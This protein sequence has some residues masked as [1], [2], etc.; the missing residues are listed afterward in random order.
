[1]LGGSTTPARPLVKTWSERAAVWNSAPLLDIVASA[2]AAVVAFTYLYF[3]LGMPAL[4]MYAP[5]KFSH[6]SL[7]FLA[8]MK[9]TVETGWWWYNPAIGAPHGFQ[10]L[11]FPANTNVDQ[12]LVWILRWASRDPILVSNAAW[13]VIVALSAVTAF[14]S[15][16]ALDISRPA[17]VVCGVLFA[18]TPYALYRHIEHMNLVIYLVPPVCALAVRIATADPDGLRWKAFAGLIAGSI[19]LCFNYIYYTFFGC[20]LLLVSTL[21]GAF[22]LRGLAV[23]RKGVLILILMIGCTA[24]NLAPSLAVLKR[25]G[26]PITVDVKRPAESEQ[27]GLKV[28]HLVSPVLRHP[29]PLLRTWGEKEVDAGFPLDGE[30]S[31]T[32]LGLVGST[33]FLTALALVILNLPAGHRRAVRV[34]TAAGRLIIA[35]IL[36]AAVGGFGSLFSLLVTPDIRAWNRVC[37]FIAFLS[38]VPV[39]FGLDWFRR[40]LRIATALIVLLLAFGVWDQ[41]A[42]LDDV[43]VPRPAAADEFRNVEGMVTR[44]AAHLP[45]G[46]AVLQLP[47]AAYL[48]ET[49]SFGMEPYD[50]LKPYLASRNSLRWSYPAM[51]NEQFQWQ[52]AAAVLTPADLASAAVTDGFSA[53]LVDTAGYQDGGAEVISGLASAGATLIVEQ[54]RYRAFTLSGVTAGPGVRERPRPTPAGACEGPPLYVIDLVNGKQLR[55]GAEVVVPVGEQLRI[56]GWFVIPSTGRTAIALDVVLDGQTFPAAY[57]FDRPD[58]AAYYNDPDYQ[59]S[60]FRVRVPP[61]RLRAGTLSFQLRALAADRSCYVETPRHSIVLR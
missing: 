37:P 6:D 9:A 30:N 11:L 2:A 7:V 46:A 31:S 49:G 54:G 43:V 53:I 8:Q 41:T 20:F 23:A 14:W 24:L 52:Q 44:L 35:M 19:L 57:G 61:D 21:I 10:A 4:G 1:M 26:D 13:M 55:L 56:T 5:L 33:G 27:H 42:A 48:S 40:R 34:S 47:F 32:R 29:W 12:A 39:G 28:R 15:L 3:A 25:F 22:S 18:L 59:R 50:H 45:A 36:L 38:L 60:G 16:R 51:T 17:A 58:V